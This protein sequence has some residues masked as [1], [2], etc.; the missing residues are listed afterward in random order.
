MNDAMA[1]FNAEGEAFIVCGPT[2]DGSMGLS[3]Q[4]NLK[5]LKAMFR[6]IRD[7]LKERERI[8]NHPT[9]PY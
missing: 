9:R 6:H 8:G 7:T 1:R 5:Q 2:P 3:Y 4:G